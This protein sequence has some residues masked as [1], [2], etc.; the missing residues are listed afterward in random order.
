MTA[1]YTRAVVRRGDGPLHIATLNR[2]CGAWRGIGCGNRIPNSGTIAYEGEDAIQT[3]ADE[4][5]VWCDDCATFAL[6]V[7][8]SIPTRTVVPRALRPTG[9]AAR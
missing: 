9:W 3:A 5:A 4:D 1:P 8:R 2:T 7:A 6:Q